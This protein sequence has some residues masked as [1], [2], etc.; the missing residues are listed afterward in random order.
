M[1]QPELSAVPV[2]SLSGPATVG[3]VRSWLAMC[4][5]AGLSEQ[6]ELMDCVLCV[7]LPVIAT[8]FIQCGEHP[9]NEEVWDVVTQVHGCPEVTLAL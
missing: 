9:G 1:N 8:E 5:K 4:D 2:I 7:E 6:A 3:A